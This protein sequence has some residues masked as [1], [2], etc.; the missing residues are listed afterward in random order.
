MGKGKG[1][2]EVHTRAAKAAATRRPR[3]VIDAALRSRIE[4]AVQQ[5]IDVLDGLEPDADLEAAGDE[6][7]DDAD[8]E[9]S[10][11]S[12]EHHPFP[13][14]TMGDRKHN[15][16]EKWADYTPNGAIDVEGDEHDG[17]EPE[18]TDES[19]DG[20]EPDEDGEPWLGSFDQMTN[21]EKSWRQA[22]DAGFHL[23][24]EVGHV[25]MAADTKIKKRLRKAAN[26]GGSKPAFGKAAADARLVRRRPRGNIAS[27]S[28]SNVRELND[29][30][31]RR[32]GLIPA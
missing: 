14:S 18:E 1:G 9:P 24:R 15:T 27:T 26:N 16:Q 30:E 32:M 17:R 10:L 20:G 5:M 4:A 28:V 11:G 7:D 8:S 6:L 31:K 19:H 23:D 25:E 22:G 21:Q 29:E 2:A 13:Y 3:R 12:A